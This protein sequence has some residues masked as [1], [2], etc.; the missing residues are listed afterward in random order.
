MPCVLSENLSLLLFEITMDAA[1]S[2]ALSPQEGGRARKRTD[3]IAEVR[4]VQKLA[5]KNPGDFSLGF[6]V[7][8]RGVEPLASTMRM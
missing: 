7:E 4:K 1:A 2:G 6:C 3:F 5:K 8:H